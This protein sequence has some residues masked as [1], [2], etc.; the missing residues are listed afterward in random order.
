MLYI[1]GKGLPLLDI[2]TVIQY[3]PTCTPTAI[4]VNY[5]GDK[6]LKF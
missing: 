3:H 6:E 5:I 4:A 2:V 1:F